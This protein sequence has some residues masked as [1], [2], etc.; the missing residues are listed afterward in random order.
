M[1]DFAGNSNSLCVILSSKF[2]YSNTGS[3]LAAELTLPVIYKVKLAILNRIIYSRWGV[4]I[5]N[6]YFL[7]IEFSNRK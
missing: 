6:E 2:V 4:Y 3:F 1:S 7:K 5:N